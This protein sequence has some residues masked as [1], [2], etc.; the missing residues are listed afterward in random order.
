MP[1]WTRNSKGE[2]GQGLLQ[3]TEVFRVTNFCDKEHLAT[4]VQPKA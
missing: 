4:F 1:Q 2:V 3:I